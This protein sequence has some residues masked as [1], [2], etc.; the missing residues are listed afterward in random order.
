MHF[1]HH[2]YSSSLAIDST[3]PPILGISA[4]F[5]GIDSAVLPVPLVPDY[6]PSILGLLVSVDTL[7]MQ[8]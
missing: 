6:Q 3:K 8:V 4:D 2:Y 1:N 5:E 7:D